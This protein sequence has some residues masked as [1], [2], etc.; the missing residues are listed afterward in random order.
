M[1]RKNPA[2]ALVEN[3]EKILLV[4][5]G[6]GIWGLPGGEME[7]GETLA[8]CGVRETLEETGLEITIDPDEHFLGVYQEVL[9]ESGNNVTD[10]I[11]IGQIVPGSLLK[12][13]KRAKFHSL[14]EIDKLAKSGKVRSERQIQAVEDYRMGLRGVYRIITSKGRK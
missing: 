5:E 8:E 10:T 4:K 1:A 9:T 7:E 3:D 12:L 2:R 14:E 6:S 13:I 11:F